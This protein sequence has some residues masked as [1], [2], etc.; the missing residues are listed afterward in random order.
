ML[1]LTKNP[2][3]SLSSVDSVGEKGT[4]EEGKSYF[5]LLAITI[6]NQH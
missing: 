5:L 6:H 4:T 3:S 1:T 2:P